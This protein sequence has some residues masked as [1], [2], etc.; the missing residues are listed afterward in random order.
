[1]AADNKEID[2]QDR[3]GNTQELFDSLLRRAL[4]FQ[5]AYQVIFALAVRVLLESSSSQLQSLPNAPSCGVKG[6]LL[7]GDGD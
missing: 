1:M 6:A 3:Y 5:R 7:K 4:G 2:P